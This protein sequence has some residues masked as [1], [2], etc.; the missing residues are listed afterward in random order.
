MFSQR[1]FLMLMTITDPFTGLAR[2]AMIG[3]DETE[4]SVF[5]QTADL[6]YLGTQEIDSNPLAWA[7]DGT[8]LFQLFE[9]PSRTLP[10][11]LQTKFFAAES[12]FIVEGS[13]SIYV[14]V[15]NKMVGE[16]SITFSSTTVDAIGVAVPL[17]LPDWM[18][19]EVVTQGGSFEMS[20]NPIA[21]PVPPSGPVTFGTGTDPV[22]AGVGLGLTMTTVAPDF[23][24]VNLQLGYRD[25]VGI[26]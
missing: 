14:S 10:K 5:S 16:K 22:V 26:A 15:E 9:A 24:L 2:N 12:S 6:I 1:T 19:D 18:T 7:T 11:I 8:R 13:H 4:W 25:V 17:S 3:W 23:E 21:F 20:E